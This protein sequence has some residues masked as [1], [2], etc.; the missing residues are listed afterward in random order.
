VLN[1]AVAKCAAH[2]RRRHVSYLLQPIQLAN[3]SKRAAITSDFARRYAMLLS[4]TVAPIRAARLAPA[5]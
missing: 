5:G 3:P 1:E 2:T 4:G